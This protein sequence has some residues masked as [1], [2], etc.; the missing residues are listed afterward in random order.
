[1]EAGGVI[2]VGSD[3]DK[4]H[5]EAERLWN[6]AAVYAS[7]ARPRFPYGDGR[8]AERIARVLERDLQEDD[9]LTPK[10]TFVTPPPDLTPVPI[11]LPPAKL[12]RNR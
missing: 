1:V 2:L 9:L 12:P 11:L 5:L 8:A 10:P 4:F 6:D 7:M 3:P